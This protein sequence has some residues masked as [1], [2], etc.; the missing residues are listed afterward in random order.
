MR[1]IFA[2]LVVPLAFAAVVTAALKLPALVVNNSSPAP[3]RLAIAPGAGHTVVPAK[4]LPSAKHLRRVETPVVP[5]VLAPPAIAAQPVTAA[6]GTPVVNRRPARPVLTVRHVRRAGRVIPVAGPAANRRHNLPRP[7]R[8]RLP[9]PRRPPRLPPSRSTGITGRRLTATSRS[10]NRPRSAKGA[11]AV[12][13]AGTV[14]ARPGRKRPG[15][16]TT[17]SGSRPQARDRSRPGSGSRQSGPR[18]PQA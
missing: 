7:C 12:E 13:V 9:L 2:V 18:R 5:I 8:S 11:E 15:Q 4:A 10:R 17:R 16:V 1:R 6:V 14:R 3:A